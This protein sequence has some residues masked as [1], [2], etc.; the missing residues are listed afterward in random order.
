MDADVYVFDGMFFEYF[1]AHPWLVPMAASEIQNLNDFIG[2]AIDGVKVGDQYY[3]IPLLGCANILFYLKSDT[4]LAN[5]TTLSEIDNTL[6]QCT[7]TSEIPPDR[8]A[9]MVDLAGGTSNA[10]MYLDTE[11]AITGVYPLPLPQNQS[12]ID[13][14]AMAN[15]KLL[16]NMASYWN[17]TTDLNDQYG[18][19]A[20]F[21]EGYGRAYVGFT[22]SMSEMSANL[23]DQVGFKVMPLADVDNRP[24]FYADVIGVNTT[25]IDRGTRDLAVKLANV[26]AATDTVVASIGSDSANAYPQ[27]LMATRPSIFEILGE[28]FPIYTDMYALTQTN[29][30]MFGL[31]DTARVWLDQMKNTITG[32]VRAAYSC[33]CDYTSS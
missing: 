2:Y 7:Y 21:N 26:M 15:V 5:A 30:I 3:A 23:R 29:P 9:L 18:R 14:N 1:R 25:T 11:H 24:L 27:Y 22:E 31:N 19:A 4:A 33:G 28:Q 16:L 32:D 8:R 13:P 20:W 10:T 17:G 12:Q 6:S